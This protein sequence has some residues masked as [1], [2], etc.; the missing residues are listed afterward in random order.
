[1]AS[2]SLH[3]HDAEKADHTQQDLKSADPYPKMNEVC[4]LTKHSPLARSGDLQPG[5]RS[6]TPLI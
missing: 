6:L 5:A 3:D 1:M 2:E 4:P